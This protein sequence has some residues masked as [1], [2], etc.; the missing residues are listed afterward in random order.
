MAGFNP[1]SEYPAKPPQASFEPPPPKLK[2]E[3]KMTRFSDVFTLKK[4]REKWAL[5]APLLSS[6]SVYTRN[7]ICVCKV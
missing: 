7:K 1:A 5:D 3:A 6:A 4:K 2:I